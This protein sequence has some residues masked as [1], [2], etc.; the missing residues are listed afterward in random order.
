MND[1][2]TS[3]ADGYVQWLREQIGHQLVY[4][5]YTT[6]LVFD[7][8]GRILVQRRYDFDWLGLPG[9]ALERYENLR[10]CATRE[11]FE[12]TGLIVDVQRL[13][14]VF[15]HPQYNLH[16]PN[17]DDVQQWSVALIARPVG[18][19]LRPD[20]G[21][22]LSVQWMEVDAALPQF[23]PAYRAMID[24][25]RQ[26]PHAATLEPVYA[27]DTLTEHWHVLRPH[28]G[29]DTVILPGAM[30]VIPNER[31]EILAVRRTDNSLWTLPG[32]YADIGETTTNT[33]VREVREETGLAVEP[34]NAIGVYSDMPM[35]LALMPNNDIA[36]NIGIA[37]ECRVTGGELHADGVETSDIAYMSPDDFLAQSFLPTNDS[38]VVV[39][40]YLRRE[41][42]PVLR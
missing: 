10:T 38:P 31:G 28:V 20:G 21:E 6:M 19:T 15:S 23:P 27:E 29:H 42:W 9:G 13:V 4:L 33:I 5:V 7:D 16:Y 2:F 12:E 40:D 30:A 18:G 3:R 22:T 8:A 1:S 34:V 36:H 14:G 35:M 11:T 24:A 41:T 32:G 25:A 26:S 17:G 39:R 37:F